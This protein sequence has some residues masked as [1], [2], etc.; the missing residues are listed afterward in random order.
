MAPSVNPSS[1][2]CNGC[3]PILHSVAS[4]VPPSS[5]SGTVTRGTATI[6][7]AP[8]PTLANPEKAVCVCARLCCVCARVCCVCVCVCMCGMCVC[9]D[10]TAFLW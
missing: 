3:S 7:V 5:A 4:D 8:P 1:M 9:V 10:D 2:I 6:P